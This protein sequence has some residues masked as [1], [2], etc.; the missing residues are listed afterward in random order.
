MLK[1]NPHCEKGESFLSYFSLFSLFICFLPSQIFAEV[2][3]APVVLPGTL[4]RAATGFPVDVYRL[5]R[6]GPKGEAV[7]IPFQID[8]IND[9]SDY[10]LDQG[11]VKDR[12]DGVFDMR[13]ELSFMGE[14]FG[15]QRAPQKW[16]TA[17]SPDFV[18]EISARLASD[19]SDNPAGA[20]YLAVFNQHPLPE[21]SKKNYV[22][23]SPA[24][25]EV[26][27]SRY[28]YRFDPKNHLVALGIDVRDNSSPTSLDDKAAVWRPMLDSSTFY[29]KADLKYFLTLEINHR[30]VSSRIEAYRTGPIRTIVRVVFFYS[31]LKINFE[32]GM[33]TEISLFSNSVNLPAVMYNPVDGGKTFNSGSGFYYGFALV[34]SPASY[35]ISTNIPEYGETKNSKA[36]FSSWFGDESSPALLP[37]YSLSMRKNDLALFMEVEPSAQMLKKR[38]IPYIYKSV[39]SSK[40][41]K[42]RPNGNVAQPL[43]RSLVNLA[44]YFDLT[45]FDKGDQSIGFKL[46]FDNQADKNTLKHFSELKNWSYQLNRV[47]LNQPLPTSQP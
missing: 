18:F 2:H 45:K 33:Y 34:D 27:T 7:P 44:L 35:E 17:K 16:L 24:S 20:V 39:E 42:M 38:N 11:P 10:I 22:V 19:S 29:L 28:R 32:L 8:E 25:G 6:T 23:F 46:L 21:L 30:D 43:G 4:L 1:N 12:P 26:R 31:F 3:K 37:S 36:M 15:P 40:D 14:D 9:F 47:L 5:F 13:D 41:L